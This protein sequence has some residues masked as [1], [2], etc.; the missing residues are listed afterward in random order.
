MKSKILLS[1]IILIAG[2]LRFYNLMFG[3]P[4]FFH[5]D[6]R[7]MASAITRLNFPNQMNSEFFAYGQF[8]LYLAYF[9]ARVANVS[10]PQAIFWLRFWSAITSTLTVL[11]GYFV[12]KEV[13][14]NKKASHRGSFDVGK[15]FHPFPSNT[16]IYF[17][18]QLKQFVNFIKQRRARDLHPNPYGSHRVLD[19]SATSAV[20]S[21]PFSTLTKTSNSVN[22]GALLS[23][24][25]IAFTPALI[26]SAHFGTTESLLTFFSMLII[27]LSLTFKGST[28]QGIILALV[29][30]LALSTK[31]S[32]FLFGAVPLFA[33]FI[34]KVGIIKKLKYFSIILIFS[35]L[36]FVL[37]SPFNFLDFNSFKG[38]MNYETA[39]ALGKT[40]VFY[41]RQFENTIPILFQLEKVFPYA[42]G[43][44]IFIFGLLG[45]IFAPNLI[46]LFALFIYFLPNAFLFAKW[47]RFMTPILPLFSIF[48][49]YFI[50]KL[51]KLV[52]LLT[53]I[54]LLPG[55]IF[56]SIYTHP[57][58]RVAAS[59]W[60]YK[61]IPSGSYVLSETANV[62]DIPVHI[63]KLTPET[64]HLSPISFNFYELDENPIRLQELLNHLEKA[65]YIFV[66]SR[67]IFA[68]HMKLPEK[69]PVT[70]K[71][72]ELLFSGNLGFEKVAEFSPLPDE[73]AEETFT[74][75]DH[76]V[77][78]IYKKVEH[79]NYK[80]LFNEKSI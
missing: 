39:V 74:V 21:P 64:Y 68:N 4:H 6:E 32:A 22:Y 35:S 60:I 30:G 3:S 17:I 23:S 69:Y 78:R 29:L 72:Y 37:F 45:I 31:V 48:A 8:P 51:P 16:R 71:Y 15:G 63:P 33:F 50:Y 79:K 56:F 40:K 2:F 67:R 9:S 59:E 46:L 7:N 41:T 27:Y 54:S 11:I 43:I 12:A 57:D 26:Q 5:P 1:A 34:A 49:V 14:G 20:H 10:F 75:F 42:L 58:V 73:N 53:F 80:S 18:P 13:L 77:I 44:P 47:T 52:P 38:S 25:L 19:R 55:L 61:N 65:D 70:G 66:P 76:P 62:I 36:F 28:F 24:I